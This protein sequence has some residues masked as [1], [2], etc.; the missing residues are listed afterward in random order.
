VQH[1]YLPLHYALQNKA[2][3]EVVEALLQAYP[4]AASTPDAVCFRTLVAC[5]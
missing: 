1:R 2:E 3:Q 5:A 4:A